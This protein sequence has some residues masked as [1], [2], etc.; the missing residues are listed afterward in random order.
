MICGWR[1][2]MKRSGPKNEVKEKKKKRKKAKF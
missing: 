2:V 1:V